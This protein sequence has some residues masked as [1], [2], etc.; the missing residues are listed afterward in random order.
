MII[1]LVWILKV[2]YNNKFKV[3]SPTILMSFASEL[4]ERRDRFS[5]NLK[6]VREA[7][8]GSD[9]YGILEKAA[10]H[11]HLS[12]PEE[13]ALTNWLEAN[14]AVAAY[15]AESSPI[16]EPRDLEKDNEKDYLKT[17][18]RE[19]AKYNRKEYE[20]WAKVFSREP[21]LSNEDYWDSALNS[22]GERIAGIFM[23]FYEGSLE[24]VFHNFGI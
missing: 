23:G 19:I 10:F 22:M 4:K 21:Q 3:E 20:R 2:E 6:Q 12:R 18:L 11:L 5:R 9:L 16:G 15:F 7:K 1:Y 24:K 17:R 13:T 8:R 14:R